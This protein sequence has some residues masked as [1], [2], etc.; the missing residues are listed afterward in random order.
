MASISVRARKINIFVRAYISTF[1]QSVAGHCRKVSYVKYRKNLARLRL[2]TYTL[3]LGMCVFG[4]K[5]SRL[6][7]T[8]L[9]NFRSE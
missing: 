7:W 9:L 5:Y 1:V 6:S 3:T 2:Y 8:G 4:T